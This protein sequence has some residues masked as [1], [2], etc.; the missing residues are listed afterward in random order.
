MSNPNADLQISQPLIAFVKQAEGFRAVAYKDSASPPVWT[1]GYGEAFVPGDSVRTEPQAAA[2][3]TKRLNAIAFELRAFVTVPLTQNQFDALIDFSYNVGMNAFRGSTLRAMVNS[4]DF[5]GA[6]GQFL[7]WTR[8]GSAHPPGLVKRRSAE[9][10]IFTSRDS[11]WLA[12]AI[13]ILG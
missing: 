12:G 8:A 2:N 11:D 13:K 10:Y 9:K 3:L 5:E 6:A 7:L 4:Q 1:V